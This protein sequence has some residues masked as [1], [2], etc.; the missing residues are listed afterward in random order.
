MLFVFM[1]FSL[2]TAT[3]LVFIAIVGLVVPDLF[4]L[5]LA[6]VDDD[7][8][9]LTGEDGDLFLPPFRLLNLVSNPPLALCNTLW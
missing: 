1:S 8:G 7:S 5:L 3:S 9:V 2:G 6:V 4:F